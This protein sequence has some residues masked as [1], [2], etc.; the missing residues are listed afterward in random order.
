M[1]M[2]MVSF[3]IAT[4]QSSAEDKDSQYDQQVLLFHV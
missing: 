4:T 3:T 2:M 1:S